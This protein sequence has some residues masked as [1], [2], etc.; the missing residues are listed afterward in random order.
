MRRKKLTY[1]ILMICSIA[2]MLVSG[3]MFVYSAQQQSASTSLSVT[4]DGK[5]VDYTVQAFYQVAG[6]GTTYN[7]K[8]DSNN[9]TLTFHAS[10]QSSTQTLSVKE[11]SGTVALSATETFVLFTYV[12]SNTASTGAYGMEVTLTGSASADSN[13]AV[14]YLTSESSYTTTSAGLGNQAGL[15]TGT[16]APTSV[17]VKAG[18]TKYFYILVTLQDP[19]LNGSYNKSASP[20]AWTVVCSNEKEPSAPVLPTVTT[21]SENLSE[22]INDAQSAEFLVNK[23]IEIVNGAVV[24]IT[25]SNIDISSANTNITVTSG[26][27]TINVKWHGIENINITVGSNGSL[28]L[29]NFGGSIGYTG[30]VIVNG[31]TATI[32]DTR[33]TGDVTITDGTTTTENTAITGDVTI[34]GGTANMDNSQIQGNL[35]ISGTGRATISGGNSVVMGMSTTP[36]NLTIYNGTFAFDPSPYALIPE[37]YEVKTVNQGNMTLYRVVKQPTQGEGVWDI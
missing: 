8:D 23:N 34:T 19:T 4:F 22:T 24:E 3:A 18:D 25:I 37:G 2:I 13:M 32:S 33:I 30:D 29:E 36:S 20:L 7:M 27:L 28:I 12:F 35:I 21:I 26:S 1:A 6:S 16:T 11:N 10:D 9:S 17:F 15:V 14:T 5:N 31:G